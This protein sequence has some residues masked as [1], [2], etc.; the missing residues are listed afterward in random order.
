MTED[1]FYSKTR[2]PKNDSNRETQGIPIF[3]KN[4]TTVNYLSNVYTFKNKQ[5]I[6]PRILSYVVE[7]ISYVARNKRSC[8]VVKLARSTFIHLPSFNP[9]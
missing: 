4:I 6:G 1:H 8:G 7:K 9:H 5:V 2:T 3:M